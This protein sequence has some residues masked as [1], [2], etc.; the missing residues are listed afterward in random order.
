MP[1]IGLGSKII[2]GLRWGWAM[3]A[4]CME[5]MERTSI[6]PGRWGN[7]TA[8]PAA[9]AHAKAAGGRMPS[10]MPPGLPCTC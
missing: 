7:T 10:K 1:L 8:R 9:I 6:A 3:A 5:Y 4:D 2:Q